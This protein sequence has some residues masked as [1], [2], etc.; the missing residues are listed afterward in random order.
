MPR[1]RQYSAGGS[2]APSS[3]AAASALMVLN[4]IVSKKGQYEEGIKENHLF[5]KQVAERLAIGGE[6]EKAFAHAMDE[7]DGSASTDIPDFLQEQ[8][9]RVKHLSEKNVLSLREVDLF[10]TSL[11]GLG[12]VVKQ[13]QENMENDPDGG[14]LPN[15]EEDLKKIMDE[16]RRNK[17]ASA[18]N[19]RDESFCRE[20]RK[21]LGEKE[22]PKKRKAGRKSAGDDDDDDDDLEVVNMPGSQNLKCPVTGML[23]DDPVKNKVCGHV[24]S[25]AGI[26][27]LLNVQGR[28]SCPVA[29]CVN[30]HVER[31][32]L[33]N[34]VEMAMKVRKFIRREKMEKEQ[35]MS[36]M[37]MD[38]YDSDAEM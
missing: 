8:R 5:S 15:Y 29:G 36:Q 22:T 2:G 34:D 6:L 32:Q 12:E 28:K 33:E 24:Y 31:S 7:E 23:F 4:T 11:G 1:A 16:Q 20:I 14:E 26:E 9:E 3:G 35:R 21:T 18:L 25:K 38:D 30:A 37:A 17:Q 13:N 19:L 10:V 27:Q